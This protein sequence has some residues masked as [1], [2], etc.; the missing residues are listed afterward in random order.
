MHHLEGQKFGRLTVLGYDHSKNHKRY[1]KC[2]CDCGNIIATR[3]DSLIG[4]QTRSCGCFQHE[5]DLRNLGL[6]EDSPNPRNFNSLRIKYP[7]LYNIW[8]HMKMRCTNKNDKNFKWYGARKITVCEAWQ[9]DYNAF[10]SWSLSHGYDD[11]LTIDRIDV[12][13]NYEPNN[14]RWITIQEQQKNKRAGRW[15]EPTLTPTEGE[16]DTT[17]ITDKGDDSQ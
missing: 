2:R 3:T 13:G 11:S 6:S 5:S 12:N 4:G 10:A 9:H 16:K 8:I 7:R 17:N 1:W 15:H 14:C